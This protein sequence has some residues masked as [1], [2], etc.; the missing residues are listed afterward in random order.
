MLPLWPAQG[1]SK[2][3]PWVSRV[4]TVKNAEKTPRAVYCK[5]KQAQL[6]APPVASLDA[7]GVTTH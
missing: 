4:R 2:R 5:K 7:E 1:H 3:S 6:P